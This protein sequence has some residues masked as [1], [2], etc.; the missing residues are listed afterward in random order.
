MKQLSPLVLITILAFF[1]PTSF[2]NQPTTTDQVTQ[3]AIQNID[4]NR[5]GIEELSLLKGIGS[6]KAQAIIEYREI[7]GQFTSVD[8][9]LNVKGIGEKVLSDNQQRLKI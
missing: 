8:D 2:A 6:K 3:Q 7:Y 4:I 9:L 5:A 1:T